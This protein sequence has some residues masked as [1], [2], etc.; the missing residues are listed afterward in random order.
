MSEITKM[1]WLIEALLYKVLKESR[2]NYKSF[3]KRSEEYQVW[4]KREI[5]VIMNEIERFKED[6]K[7]EPS[8]G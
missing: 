3:K 1:Q 5:K 7:D 4:F 6:L 8:R 2:K